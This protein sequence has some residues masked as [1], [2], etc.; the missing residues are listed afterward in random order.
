MALE[1][2]YF[3][4]ANWG[5]HV[6]RQRV[7]PFATGEIQKKMTKPSEFSLAI[8][9][10]YFPLTL[11]FP[12]KLTLE[13][14][15]VNPGQLPLKVPRPAAQSEIQNGGVAVS[16]RNRFNKQFPHNFPLTKSDLLAVLM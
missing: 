6:V 16:T 13:P 5:S 7:F 9:L 10:A 12:L 3:L 8:L 2:G 4:W 14:P 15:S 1:M 11:K